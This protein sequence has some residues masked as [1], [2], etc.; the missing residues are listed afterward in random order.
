MVVACPSEALIAAGRDVYQASEWSE[1]GIE[2]DN[3]DVWTGA[4]QSFDE[5]WRRARVIADGHLSR[6]HPAWAT[7]GPDKPLHALR[8]HKPLQL[9][10]KSALGPAEVSRQLR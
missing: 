10:P 3:R 2:L 6:L 1:I 9:R 8:Q 7:T 4:H 5:H